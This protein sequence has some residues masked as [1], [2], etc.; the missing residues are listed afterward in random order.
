MKKRFAL[1]VLAA[2]IGL[3]VITIG[4]AA[5]MLSFGGAP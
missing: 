2:A 4:P 5:L 1:G 3:A